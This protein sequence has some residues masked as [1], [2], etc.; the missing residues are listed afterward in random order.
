MLFI[1]ILLVLY[2]VIVN[3]YYN[4]IWR[5]SNSINNKCKLSLNSNDGGVWPPLN[6]I[7]KVKDESSI[8]KTVTTEE[9]AV[10]KTESHES[11]SILITTLSGALASYFV[12]HEFTSVM[13]GTLLANSLAERRDTIGT[14]TR[15][16]GNKVKELKKELDTILSSNK[17]IV[18]TPHRFESNKAG[19]ADP[20]FW[21]EAHSS[22][23]YTLGNDLE[24]REKHLL[25]MKKIVQEEERIIMKQKIEKGVF[26]AEHDSEV[27]VIKYKNHEKSAWRPN[28]SSLSD[29]GHNVGNFFKGSF[30]NAKEQ[31]IATIDEWKRIEIASSPSMES[32]KP[33]ATETFEPLFSQ[34][35]SSMSFKQ[36]GRMQLAALGADS[37]SDYGNDSTGLAEN[38]EAMKN[39]DIV[40][41]VNIEP[42]ITE[43]IPEIEDNNFVLKSSD[44]VEEVEI[45]LD[46][47]IDSSNSE[48]LDNE[49]IDYNN[50]AEV[51]EFDRFNQASDLERFRRWGQGIEWNKVK[52]QGSN[53]YYH[54]QKD[55]LF[56][57]QSLP[58]STPKA[59]IPKS[60]NERNG[61][62]RDVLDKA[63]QKVISQR[64]S[65]Q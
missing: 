9:G 44:R 61:W 33:A 13:I 59:M 22:V 20:Q 24:A 53:L 42:I 50:M 57:E 45:T 6:E 21:A 63:T 5:N 40:A 56:P 48:I 62:V 39:D 12:S 35:V 1:I 36:K 14:T 28:F 32:M 38:V 55:K 37:Y 29:I 4:N 15:T 52:I 43:N 18:S 49:I 46:K 10:A 3:G 64:L 65:Q 47:N 27:K 7:S 8:I 19:L 31:S 23:S 41:E 30:A 17:K 26:E 16:F 51:Q 25:M 34:Q 11:E 54:I 58:I 2:T 60:E